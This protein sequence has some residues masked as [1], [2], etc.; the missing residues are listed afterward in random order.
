[1]KNRYAGLV[2]YLR[3]DVACAPSAAPHLTPGLAGDGDEAEVADRRAVGLGVAVDHHDA[4]AA[5]GRREGA[6]QAD[7]TGADDGEIE[8]LVGGQGDSQC[9]ERT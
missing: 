9:G 3:P 1:M 5:S 6:G 2:G 8:R 7:D 4:L